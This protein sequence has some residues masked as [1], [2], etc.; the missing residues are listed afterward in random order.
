M[1]G[2]YNL[3]TKLYRHVIYVNIKVIRLNP[4]VTGISYD[5]VSQLFMIPALLSC[6]REKYS[7]KIYKRKHFEEMLHA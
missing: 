1:S 5:T 2:C 6:Y 4:L 7:F 3:A